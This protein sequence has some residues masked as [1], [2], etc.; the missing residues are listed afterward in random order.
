MARQLFYFDNPTDQRVTQL[1]ATLGID[2]DLFHEAAEMFQTK[3]TLE[4][5]AFPIH[6]AAI[7]RAMCE[8]T[9]FTVQGVAYPARSQGG[10]R[11]G[12]PLGDILFTL[13]MTKVLRKTRMALQQEDLIPKYQYRRE[14][15]F[16]PGGSSSTDSA[17]AIDVSCVDDT[18]YQA[19]SCSAA[20]CVH[21][22][23]KLG[24]IVFRTC[25]SCGFTLNYG[26][27]KS[28]VLVQLRGQGSKSALQALHQNGG[29]CIQVTATTRVILGIIRK[30]KHLGTYTTLA[31]SQ[32]PEIKDRV[33]LASATMKDITKR[34]FKAGAMLHQPKMRFHESL[35]ETKLF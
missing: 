3:G 22:A 32:L 18:F 15:F 17:S 12:D 23:Q 13:A 34:V 16:Y 5:A 7:L 19:V 11:A 2:P 29:L 28:E 8:N 25:Q 33:N 14:S 26:K 20:E 10:T 35:V 9:W 30:Y 4:E 27:G 31:G 21:R 24:K 6:L 1:M